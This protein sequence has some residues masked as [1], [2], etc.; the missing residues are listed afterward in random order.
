LYVVERATSDDYRIYPIQDPANRVN[1]YLF[2]DG[3]QALA[4][5]AEMM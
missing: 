5:N 1:Q 3:W 4:E 2:D